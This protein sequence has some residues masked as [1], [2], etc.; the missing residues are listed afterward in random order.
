[1]YIPIP[2][3]TYKAIVTL[4]STTR[5]PFVTIVLNTIVLNDYGYTYHV[6]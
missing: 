1:M 2:E 4:K 5:C 3:F 6:L